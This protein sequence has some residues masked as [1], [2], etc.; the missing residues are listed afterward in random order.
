MG[1]GPGIIH[2]YSHCLEVTDIVL[3]S[4]IVYWGEQEIWT[5]FVNTSMLLHVTRI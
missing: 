3:K 2:L 1:Q 5:D 4:I